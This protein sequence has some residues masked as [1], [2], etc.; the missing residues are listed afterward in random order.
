MKNNEPYLVSEQ[1]EALALRDKFAMVALA[2]LI[3]PVGPISDY[4]INRNSY[5]AYRY[6]DA[7]M[8]ARLAKMPLKD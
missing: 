7:M 4:D 5:D 1:R 2:G 8:K 3:I 6:A